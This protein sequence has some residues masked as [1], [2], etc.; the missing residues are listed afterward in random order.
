MTDWLE[1]VSTLFWQAII[2]YMIIYHR[3]EISYFLR[4]VNKVGPGGIEA[5]VQSAVDE[6]DKDLQFNKEDVSNLD[7]FNVAEGFFSG[8]QLHSIIKQKYRSETTVGEVLLFSTST[9]RTWFVATNKYLYCI[10]DDARTRKSGRLIQWRLSL[11]TG[12][13]I[14][15][16]ET[17]ETN[18][19]I[20]V[21]SRRNWL[22]SRS[23]YSTPQ[24]AVEAVE[25]LI[26]DAKKKK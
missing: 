9:Q 6:P 5:A 11:S 1:F 25:S 26:D 10:L 7:K 4:R 17:S 24:Q 18:G 8:R 15:A 3:R 19:T 22:Y 12:H 21:G 14:E 13:N 2:V 23:I 20:D 16:R